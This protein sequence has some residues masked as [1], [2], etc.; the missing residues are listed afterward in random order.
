MSAGSGI[1]AYMFGSGSG[2]VLSP[3]AIAGLEEIFERWRLRTPTGESAGLMEQIRAAVRIENR[4]M[5]AWRSQPSVGLI[6][7]FAKG[8]IVRANEVGVDELA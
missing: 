3:E 2:R 5:A 7:R 4:A 1:L 8:R 6:K